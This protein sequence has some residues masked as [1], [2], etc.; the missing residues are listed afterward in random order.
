MGPMKG[1]DL[2]ALGLAHRGSANTVISLRASVCP[3]VQHEGRHFLSR[4]R[5]PLRSGMTMRRHLFR[6]WP[7]LLIAAATTALAHEDATLTEETAW[8]AWHLT[9]DIVIP[10]ALVA[11][12][13]IVGMLRRRTVT[14]P[15]PGWRHVSFF[16]GLATVFLAL[17]SPIEPIA[18]RLFWMHQ[19]EYL[20]LW[21]LGPMLI[22][23]SWPQETLSPGLRAMLGSNLLKPIVSNG[24][25]RTV[26]R[27]LAQ[28]AVATILFI[29]A[30]YVWEVPRNH[31]L[32]IVDNGVLYLMHA[33]LLLAGLL[34]WWLIFDRR[35]A[36]E[37]LRYGVRLMMLWVVTL[38]NIV[39]GAYIVLKT[40]VLYSAYDIAG[41]LFGISALADEQLGGFIIWIPGSMMCLFGILVV[42]HMWARQETIVAER[43][44]VDPSGSLALAAA[45]L[46]PAMVSRQRSKN[47]ALAIGCIAFVVAIFATALLVGV[48]SNLYGHHAGDLEAGSGQAVHAMHGDA[49]PSL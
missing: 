44:V 39:L 12:I 46:T 21:M 9:P 4:H 43:T 23:L 47:R 14:E 30:L 17:Q 10:T 16:G 33:T 20:L 3:Q 37:G 24:A 49:A 45:G 35:P 6:L 2:A 31:N 22:A 34:F 8:T 19:I 38:S 40:D 32:A 28:P 26:F 48:L 13:Y 27:L 5:Q 25:L 42:T 36:P 7:V 1:G 41:R 15:L 18:E 29:A 11:I